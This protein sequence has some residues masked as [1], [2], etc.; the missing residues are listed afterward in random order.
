[1]DYNKNYNTTD[2]GWKH[3]RKTE[4]FLKRKSFQIKCRK[5]EHT[6]RE[7]NDINA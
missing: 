4:A 1:M 3:L 6:K 7:Q 5:D 2:E